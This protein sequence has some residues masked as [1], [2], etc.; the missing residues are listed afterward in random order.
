[1]IVME[2]LSILSISAQQLRRLPK[3][4]EDSLPVMPST[5][6][7]CDV[8]SLFREPY[9]HSGYRPV[10]QEWRVYLLSLFQQHNEALNVWTHLLAAVAVFLRFWAFIETSNLSLDAYSLPLYIFVLSAL[11]YLSFSVLA[12]LFQSKSELTHYS[13]Y[14]LDYVGVSIYQYGSSLAHYFYSSEQSWH[15][16]MAYIFLPGAAFLGWLSCTGCC[17]AKYRYQ[18][19]YPVERKICQ[20]IPAGLAY[21]L[22]I[23][24]IVH[25]IVTCWD[26]PAVNFH[27]LQIVFFLLA[28]FFF[29]YPV[30]EKFFPGCCDIVGHAHQIF[31]LFLSLCTLCQMEGLLTDFLMRRD[32]LLQRHTSGM[33][34]VVSV[35]FPVLVMCSMLT[36]GYLRQNVQ[37]HLNKKEK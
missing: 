6:K 9:I 34:V 25:R 32:V 18:R 22:D 2:H 24:P 30:P 33:V 27:T 4:L 16:K 1:M 14:F 26:D 36:A 7:D 21:I 37:L 19:P 31:H 10:G 17:Y 5:V 11:I 8:P 35:S 28:A 12:H 15:N 3:V 20:V 13:F 29:S 23:S